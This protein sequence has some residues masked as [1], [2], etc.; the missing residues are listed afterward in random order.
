MLFRSAP[1]YPAPNSNNPYSPCSLAR[2]LTPNPLIAQFL[3][4][5]AVPLSLILL[6]ASF[7]RMQIPRP[8][9]RLPIMA[10]FAAALAKMALLPVIG[11][12]VVQGMVKG[13]LIPREAL[14]ERFVAMFLSGTPAA[15][16]YVI[17]S[18]GAISGRWRLTDG[19]FAI[20]PADRIVFVLHHGRRR[21]AFGE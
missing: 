2:S 20:Q 16:K 1:P 14:A 9:S 5:I 17:L 18:P 21:H 7:A 19:G 8:L 11:V 13:G 10:M 12:F 4:D 3:G 15:V 6:G